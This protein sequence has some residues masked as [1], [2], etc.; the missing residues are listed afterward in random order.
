MSGQIGGSEFGHHPFSNNAIPEVSM[1]NTEELRTS[2]MPEAEVSLRLAFWLLERGYADGRVDV[3]IDG[4]QVRIGDTIHFDLPRFLLELDC[5]KLSTIDAWQCEYALASGSGIVYVHSNPGCGDV[6]ARLRTGHTLRVECKKGPL[7]RSP[8]SQEYPLIREALGQLL[9]V[10]EIGENDILAV[11][12]PHT[13]KFE[14][15]AVRWRNAPLIKRFGIRILTVD[16]NG[17]VFGME[18]A[19]G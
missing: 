6:V 5:R 15:L 7:T 3:A 4:A 13:T 8:S 17:S 10:Q 12:V 2:R 19:L 18:E 14:E 11:A 16:R 1:S 9:T